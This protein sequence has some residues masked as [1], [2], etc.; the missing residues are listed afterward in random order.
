MGKHLILEHLD[1]FLTPIKHL[2]EKLD[3]NKVEKSEFNEKITFL[4]SNKVGKTQFNQVY[5]EITEIQNEVEQKLDQLNPVIKGSLSMNREEDSFIGIASATL[6]EANSASGQSSFASGLQNSASGI[7]AHAEGW[8]SNASGE[9]SHAEG[10]YTNALH[11]YTH[12]EGKYTQ[13]KGE[14]SHAEGIH[15]IAA[16]SAQHV[17]GRYN[18]QDTENKY[19]HIVGRGRSDRRANAHTLD[20]NGNAWFHGTIKLG[21]SN[22]EDEASREV[23]LKDQIPTVISKLTNDI[24]YITAEE[25]PEGFSG[26]YNDLINKPIISESEAYSNDEIISLLADLEMIDSL[27]DTESNILT[28]SENSVILF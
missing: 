9:A 3:N 25:I 18:I 14:S 28:D 17:Q 11:N 15:T 4:N 20:W 22:Q 2:I 23:A 13:A 19:A 27:L 16:G 1:V 7:A 6:G 21:G 5:E 26:D 8:S 12:T 10:Y 24:G